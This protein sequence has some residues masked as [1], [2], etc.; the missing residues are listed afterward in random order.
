MR[1]ECQIKLL[2]QVCVTCPRR[3]RHGF[4]STTTSTTKKVCQGLDCVDFTPLVL[5]AGGGMVYAKDFCT[6]CLAANKGG[7][8]QPN[9]SVKNKRS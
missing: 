6:E 4:T 7:H 5:K 3:E 2:V 9:P 8:G 1:G